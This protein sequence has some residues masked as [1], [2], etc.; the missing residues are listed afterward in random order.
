V[1][2]GDVICYGERAAR[3]VIGCGARADEFDAAVRRWPVAGAA[4]LAAALALLALLA[5]A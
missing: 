4:L 2:E 3:A 1:P 5:A